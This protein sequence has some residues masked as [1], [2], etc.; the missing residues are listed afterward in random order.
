V[1]TI[2]SKAFAGLVLGMALMAGSATGETSELQVAAPVDLQRFLQEVRG[3]ALKAGVSAATFERATR[4]LEPD[5]QV[6]MLAAS[7]PEHVKPVWEYLDGLVNDAR[8]ATGQQKLVEL[9]DTLAAIERAYGVDRHVVLAIW[10][11]ESNYGTAQ[12][13]RS[14][15]RSLATL[16]AGDQRRSQFWRREFIAALR[17]LEEGDVTPERMTGSWAGAMGHTQFMPTACHERAVDFD[18]DG[19]RDIWDS[20][21]DGL[22]SAANYLKA[23]GWRLED[24]WGFEVI[25]PKGF[26]YRLSAPGNEK[27]ASFWR[28]AGVERPGRVPVR[29]TVSPLQLIL[30]AGANGPAFLVTRNFRAILRYNPA[31]AYAL[32]VGHLADR[33]AGAEAIVSAWP[34]D[35]RPLARAEREELQKLLSE[36]G[37]DT[38]PPDGIIGRQSRAAIRAFQRISGL[39]EDGYPSLQ[40]LNLLR[41]AGRAGRE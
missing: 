16:A 21:P 22:A 1:S 36:R 38:G 23:F 19:R 11:V 39:P 20:V 17:I 6:L 13:E 31:E 3:E 26:D 41:Q 27:P 8:I 35:D 24:P 14:V 32:A 29:D 5:V 25:L 33:I 4:G 7:Q 2:L 30:P 10:G 40:L 9:A 28:Q 37:L 15:V 34:T 18:G 12:G